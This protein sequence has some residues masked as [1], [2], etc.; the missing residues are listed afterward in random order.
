MS[1]LV[2]ILYLL[3]VVLNLWF[4]CLKVL[5]CPL[6][7]VLNEF[8]DSPMYVSSLLLSDL[9]TVAWYILYRRWGTFIHMYNHNNVWSVLRIYFAGPLPGGVGMRR[10]PPIGKKIHFLPQTE[11]KK[12]VVWGGLGPKG[13]LSGVLHPPPPP[14]KKKKKKK[15][16][17]KIS[18]RA[19]CYVMQ[20]MI[21]SLWLLIM[22]LKQSYFTQFIFLTFFTR[23]FGIGCLVNIVCCFA[24]P[25][26]THQHITN[27]CLSLLQNRF[28]S[29]E[30]GRP[31]S[32]LIGINV[33]D[34]NIDKTL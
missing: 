17:E 2:S 6:Y 24:L 20:C 21:C 23:N 27:N 9:V 8:S 30:T 10:F 4:E 31:I 33:I 18:L 26:D 3:R 22:S 13:P 5:L 19:C 34:L 15:E 28:T 25:P 32:Y 16:K 7:L 12:C 14:K 29:G 11:L 1:L